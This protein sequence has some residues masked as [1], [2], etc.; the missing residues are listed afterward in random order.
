MKTYYDDPDFIRKVYV[1]RSAVTGRLVPCV[2]QKSAEDFLSLQKNSESVEKQPEKAGT[3][4]EAYEQKQE[5]KTLFEEKHMINLIA[6]R[7]AEII[8]SRMHLSQ[9]V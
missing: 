5:G 4:M 8:L 1:K 9:A 7:T 2:D 3:L 6:E